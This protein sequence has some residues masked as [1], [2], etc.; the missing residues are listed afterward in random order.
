MSNHMC[1]AGSAHKETVML[2]Q[3]GL[4][5]AT[6]IQSILGTEDVSDEEISSLIRNQDIVR[7]IEN[8]PQEN[9]AAAA[10]QLAWGTLLS[11]NGPPNLRG[12]L[13]N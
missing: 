10:L 2:Q 6:A 8:D 12:V 11:L 4:L 7:N 1:P 5:L 3:L 9:A 13:F